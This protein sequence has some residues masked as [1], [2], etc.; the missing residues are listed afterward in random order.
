MLR[1]KEEVNTAE[2]R[3]GGNAEEKMG[4][5]MIAMTYK[6]AMILHINRGQPF[7]YALV[8]GVDISVGFFP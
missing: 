4:R 7:T 8:K 6:T 5:K 3:T 1:S 2:G